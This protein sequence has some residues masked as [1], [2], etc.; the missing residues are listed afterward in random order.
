MKLVAIM[1]IMTCLSSL[2]LVVPEPTPMALVK[3]KQNAILKLVF[4][5]EAKQ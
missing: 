3:V 5:G 1:S 4:C 2:S